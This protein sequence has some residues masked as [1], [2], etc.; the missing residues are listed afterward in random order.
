MAP[1]QL[2]YESERD[3][4]VLN[5]TTHNHYVVVVGRSAQNCTQKQQFQWFLEAVIP[6]PVLRDIS[7][8]LYRF[9][10]ESSRKVCVADETLE[11]LMRLSERFKSP[12]LRIR[13]GTFITRTNEERAPMVESSDVTS[14]K[15]RVVAISD[16]LPPSFVVFVLQLPN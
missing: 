16:R 15:S 12:G 8:N 1:V 14:R 13:C 6:N 11:V 4:D 5:L 2:N 9:V 7:G 10:P 3:I